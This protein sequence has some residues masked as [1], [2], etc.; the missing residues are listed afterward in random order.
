MKI[1][2]RVRNSGIERICQDPALADEQSVGGNIV[3]GREP[4]QR[5]AGGDFY[6]PKP[7][8]LRDKGPYMTEAPS[9]SG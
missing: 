3:L 2:G 6:H 7:L 4:G 8:F 1:P 9:D 5:L